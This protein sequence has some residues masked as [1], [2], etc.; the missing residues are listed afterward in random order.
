M[1]GLAATR[2]EAGI[3]TTRQVADLFVELRLPAVT[4]PSSSLGRLRAQGLL[5]R[6]TADTWALTPAGEEKLSAEGLRIPSHL[7]DLAAGQYAGSELGDRRHALIPPFL[8]PM[9]PVGGLAHLLEDSPFEQNIMLITRFPKTLDDAVAGLIPVLQK[10][11]AGHDLRLLVAS[12]AMREDTLWANVVTY[13]WASKYAIVL[14]DKPGEALNSNVLI[15]IGGMLMSGRRCAILRDT[16][17]P[18]MP[19]DLVGHIYKPV[20][21][22]DHDA[23]AQAIHRWIRDDLGQGACPD[24]PA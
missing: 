11:T 14:L 15:E 13:M 12:D 2:S 3:F 6:P 22:A 10:V 24:C 1:S 18:A 9:G 20:V 23:C 7:L 4:N 17:V 16:S 5:M 19:T 21:L 8:G